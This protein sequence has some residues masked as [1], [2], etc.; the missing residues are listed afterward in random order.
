MINHKL[1]ES[2]SDYL[3]QQ[4]KDILIQKLT[5]AYMEEIC[6]F[7]A[8]FTALPYLAGK[9]RTSIQKFYEDAAKDE[10]YDHAAWILKRISELDGI[11]TEALNITALQNVQHKYITPAVTEETNQ[12]D[13]YQSL[14]DNKEAEQ[15]AIETYRDI[16]EYTRNIDVVTNDKIKHILADEI[17]H[18]QE[19]EDFL[20][21]Y[22]I[23]VYSEIEDEEEN[24]DI[25]Y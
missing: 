1:T 17:E 21:D 25:E 2:A 5:N 11:P 24:F 22:D 10:L 3:D 12:I 8:Y 14:L 16:E 19:I 6:A 23:I 7:Y 20:A 18:L 13:V 15:G 4:F 9:E